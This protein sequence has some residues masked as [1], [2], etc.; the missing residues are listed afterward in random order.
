VVQKITEA[1]NQ[2]F[3]A[4]KK[5]RYLWHC[6]NG[7]SSCVINNNDQKFIFN[8]AHCDYQKTL[9]DAC[10]QTLKSH[11][12]NKTLTNQE[13]IDAVNQTRRMEFIE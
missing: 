9:F 11:L 12:I 10:V 3:E 8:Q 13:L 2:Q 7:C 4:C 6:N 1:K 5:C